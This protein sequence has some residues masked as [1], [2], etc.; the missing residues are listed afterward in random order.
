MI[1]RRKNSKL[2]DYVYDNFIGLEYEDKCIDDRLND[3]I[4]KKS[5]RFIITSKVLPWMP[6]IGMFG[7]IFS[8]DNSYLKDPFRIPA[9]NAC[10]GLKEAKKDIDIITKHSKQVQNKID[11]ILIR[12]KNGQI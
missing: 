3:F 11:M 5:V 2:F 12:E 9:N 6:L 10:Y 4:K 1:E 8:S 7:L